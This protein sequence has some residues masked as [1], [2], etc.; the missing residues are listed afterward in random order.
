MRVGI[1]HNAWHI[2]GGGE[3]YLGTLAEEL[4]LDHKVTL[5][6]TTPFDRK[7]LRDLLGLSLQ[8]VEARSLCSASPVAAS[9][10]NRLGRFAAEMA[11]QSAAANYDVIIRVATGTVPPPCHA[12]SLLHVQVPFSTGQLHHGRAALRSAWNGSACRGFAAMFFN[13]VFTAGFSPAFSHAKTHAEVLYPPVDVAPACEPRPWAE[14]A[15][16]VLSVGRFDEL[17]HCKRQLE[18]VTAFR[19]M[20]NQGLQ[21]WSLVLAGTGSGRPSSERYLSRL[22]EAAAGLPIRILVNA[23]RAE[24]LQMYQSSRIYWHAAGLGCNEDEQPEK[25][26]HFGISTVEAMARGCVPV[27]VDLGGQKEIV[28][29]NVAGYRWRT[30][31]ELVRATWHVIK[32][33]RA[34]A[35]ISESARVASQQYGRFRFGR[36]ARDLVQRALQG[37]AV[38]AA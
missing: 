36:Q 2:C 10:P 35:A 17:G 11:I 7:R 22:R 31:E 29:S 23:P 37:T 28:T 38:K 3:L 27:V 18:L 20:V 13:S 14:R 6:L 5:L 21:G 26:E 33:E 24:I 8:G 16:T 34:S 19:S 12:I 9:G 1:C 15:L 32:N 30:L 4:A 25:V